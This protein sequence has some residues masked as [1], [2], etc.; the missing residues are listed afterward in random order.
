[1]ECGVFPDLEEIVSGKYLSASLLVIALASCRITSK[2]EAKV[3][4]CLEGLINIDAKW[5]A[6]SV[7]PGI[8]KAIASAIGTLHDAEARR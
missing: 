6:D 4:Q 2:E 5:S 3:I 1:M 7:T 8:L